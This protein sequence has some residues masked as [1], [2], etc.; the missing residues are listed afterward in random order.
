MKAKFRTNNNKS[1]GWTSHKLFGQSCKNI[2]RWRVRRPISRSHNT[3][4]N[5]IIQ[6][7]INHRTGNKSTNLT[8]P[9]R[10]TKSDTSNRWA[11]DKHP[12]ILRA[13]HFLPLSGFVFWGSSNVLS[14]NW[15][16]ASNKG[17]LD[18]SRFC[19]D[20]RDAMCLGYVPMSKIVYAAAQFKKVADRSGIHPNNPS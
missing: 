19:T 2:T 8:L 6:T 9:F 14:C 10:C 5:N 7:G 4:F 1:A 16:E 20:A 3:R 15:Q 13:V 18:I 11:S 17:S 12:M